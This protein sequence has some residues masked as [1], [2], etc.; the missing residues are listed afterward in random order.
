MRKTSNKTISTIIA[1]LLMS[2][3]AI[4]IFAILP[5]TNAHDPPWDVPTY[6]YINAAPN[7]VGVN[8]TV[9]VVFWLNAYMPT[10]AGNAGDRWFFYLDITTPD[11]ST[12]TVGPF[13]SDPAGG[14]YYPYKPA[15]TGKYTFTV[16]FGPQVLTGSN[17][18][19][20]YNYNIAINNT[21]LASSATTTLTVQEE[22][23]PSSPSFP[24]PTEY[25]TRPIEGQN[26]AWYTIASNW[27]GSPQI[28]GKYQPGG[29]A[30]NTAHIV[31]TKPLQFGGVVGGVNT[32]I[33]GVTFYDG[34]A[35]EGVFSNPLILY[36]RLYYPLP[37]SDATTGG[38][39][40]SVDLTTGE[41]L[42]VQN[43]T[44]NPSFGQL[45]DYE[46]MNQHGVIR[47]GYL[48]AS[49]GAIL[50]AYDPLTGSWL[51]SETNVPSGTAAYGPNGEI[52]RYV[53]NATG[54]WLALWNNTAAH[55]LTGSTNPSDTTSSNYNQWR[56]VGK[57]VD[58]SDAYSWNVSVPSLMTGATI[59][60]IIQ[61]DILLGS[62]GTLP[63]PGSS[64][65]YTVWAI[66][67]KP[68]SRGSL[69]W[70]KNYDAPPGNITRGF[71]P[72]WMSALVDPETRVFTMYDK[73]TMQWLGYSIDNGNLL[74]GPTPSEHPFNFY[75]DVGLTRYAVAYGKL[76]SAGYSGIVYCY[77]LKN[78]HELWNYS[79][80]AGLDAAYS[81]YPLGIGGIADGKVYLFTTEHSANAPHILDV[82]LRCINATDGKE[83]WTIDSYGSQGAIAIAD[84]YLVALNLYDMQIYGYGKGPSAIT[85]DASPEV[86]VSGTKVLIKGYITD[87][88]AGTEQ[89]EQAKRFPNG[90]PAVSDSSMS[91]WMEYVYMQKPK[92]E[93]TTGVL[94]NL[95]VLDSNNNFHQIG[96]AVSDENGFFS[97]DWEPDIA[98]KYTVYAR[99]AGSGSYWPSHAETAFL[100]SEPAA[101][102][103][104]PAPSQS[105]ADLYFVPMS[106]G[107]ILAVIVVGVLL[108][109]LLLRKRP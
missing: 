28:V 30:P 5:S 82:K 90:V 106:I 49:S 86:S 103:E 31:W 105:I 17:G 94:V 14:S 2:T 67:L 59:V 38:G 11:N 7:P 18:T 54:K 22:Q 29:A 64:S 51:F 75:S 95:Y 74:W 79:A 6:A 37:L 21:Y 66:S 41:T 85:V 63:A 10:A 19:G 104:P 27:L 24:L 80:P 60:T 9:N 4:P 58:A 53:L 32:G 97:Y 15:E 96:E 70:M 16:R 46:S 33:D 8:Q 92:P 107:I 72:Q 48:W 89:N 50:N 45:Y 3:I 40:I 88:S 13:T 93:N 36:G 100:V 20:I 102:S 26:T 84:G 52:L 71:A 34:T 55:G 57:T 87:I 83:L 47:N 42:W 65:P 62:N 12:E 108:A 61:D 98:G 44:V 69:L 109:F 77:D 78:G 99:F 101:T 91:G 23:L 73:E 43:Y 56:P 81:G 76:F 39:Y 68:E 35:Y 25:W 1:I